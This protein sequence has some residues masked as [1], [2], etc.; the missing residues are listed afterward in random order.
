MEVIAGVV[1]GFGIGFMVG[2]MM[3]ARDAV[4]S[5]RKFHEEGKTLEEVLEHWTGK[6]ED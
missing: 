4:N 2:K 1:F 5:L 6:D 3:L